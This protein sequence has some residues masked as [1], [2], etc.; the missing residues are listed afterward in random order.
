MG[1][2]SSCFH[3]RSNGDLIKKVEEKYPNL[4]SVM[5]IDLDLLPGKY[6]VVAIADFTGSFAGNNYKFWSISNE[7]CLQDLNITESETIC[8]SPF[9][10]L[11]ITSREFEIGNRVEICQLTLNQSQVCCKLLFGMMI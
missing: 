5:K 8:N 6:S 3:L 10:T 1:H 11:G 7:T 4:E 2:K 9:E